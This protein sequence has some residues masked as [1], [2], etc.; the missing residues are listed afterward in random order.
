MSENAIRVLLVD[1]QAM[2]RTGIRAMLSKASTIQV[3]GEA[4]HGRE[5]LAKAHLLDPD[6]ILMDVRM[7]DMDG[8]ETTR[9]LREQ[10]ARSAIIM[11]TMHQDIEYLQQAVAC[12]A[13][14]YVV[15]DVDADDLINAITTVAG[16]GSIIDPS[17]LRALL[18]RMAW[19]A[20]S[21]VAPLGAVEKLTRREEDVLALL[22]QGLSNKE[23]AERLV[24]GMETVKT[25]VSSILAKLGLSDRTQAAIYAVRHGLVAPKS[26]A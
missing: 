20:P 19:Q 25:H 26:E 10:G 6:I 5:A 2:I 8:L 11:L 24:V 1:D 22:G 23:I 12:G 4:A 13:A 21:R 7:P 15:K 3:V 9:R 17:L 14:G 18:R 16:G